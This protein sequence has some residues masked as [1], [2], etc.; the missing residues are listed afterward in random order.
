[1]LGLLLHRK[2]IIDIFPGILLLE[3]L[4]YIAVLK[5]LFH[6]VLVEVPT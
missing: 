1:M 2:V 3:S 5:L 4:R 6:V